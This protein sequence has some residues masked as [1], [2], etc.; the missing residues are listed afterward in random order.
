MALLIVDATTWVGHSTAITSDEG[1]L[2]IAVGLPPVSINF[3][4]F[5]LEKRLCEPHN[6]HLPAGSAAYGLQALRTR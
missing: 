3:T 5:R 6:V 4:R 1:C 2:I